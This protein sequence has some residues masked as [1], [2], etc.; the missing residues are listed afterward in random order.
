MQACH[1]TEAKSFTKVIQTEVVVNTTVYS[2][3]DFAKIKLLF[4]FFY[5]SNKVFVYPVSARRNVTYQNMLKSQ[6][7]K[8]MRYSR[9]VRY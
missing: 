4:S 1:S 7:E 9:K 2:L 6:A 5:S 8:C 3:Q